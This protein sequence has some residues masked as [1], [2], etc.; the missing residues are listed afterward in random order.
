MFSQE[1]ASHSDVED[2]Q[3]TDYI[4]ARVQKAQ[5]T[6][7]MEAN[8]N[9]DLYDGAAAQGPVTGAGPNRKR[10]P[11][12]DLNQGQEDINPTHNGSLT[13]ILQ[14]SFAN[15]TVDLTDDD[16]SSAMMTMITQLMC[17]MLLALWC[18]LFEW[19]KQAR[20][21]LKIFL[22][23][24]THTLLQS[25][26]CHRTKVMGIESC[27]T[28]GRVNSTHGSEPMIQPEMTG[29]RKDIHPWIHNG[30]IIGERIAQQR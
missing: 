13:E 22:T 6:V 26:S 25:R 8:M 17:L 23:G 24:C 1:D 30:Y 3:Q 10:Q 21:M 28:S 27:P 11:L 20:D 4:K 19:N 7:Q 16:Q 12:L 9:V 2:E 18:Q 14:Q 5:Q 29:E 15:M